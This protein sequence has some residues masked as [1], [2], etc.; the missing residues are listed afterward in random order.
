MGHIEFT[1]TVYFH[2]AWFS[3][4]SFHN[5]ITYFILFSQNGI[6]SAFAYLLASTAPWPAGWLGDL[7]VNKGLIFLLNVRKLYYAIGKYH[8]SHHIQMSVT[9][10]YWSY[11][12]Y[13]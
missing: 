11:P 8:F 10:Q 3:N 7:L 2:P 5:S 1:G 9:I 4:I 13:V 6:V 12:C